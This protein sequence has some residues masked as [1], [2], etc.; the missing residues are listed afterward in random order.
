M[1]GN[2]LYGA[3]SVSGVGGQG[4]VFQLNTDGSGFTV[5]HSFAYTDGSQPDPLVLANGTLYGASTYGIQGISLG[6]GALFTLTLQPTLNIALSGNQAILT[7]DDPSYSL[8]SGSSI[9]NISTK[10][11]RGD[12]SPH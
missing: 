12:A 11:N 7:W 4:T 8:Y 2:V 10:I 6:D 9:T 3:T 5:L 1:S